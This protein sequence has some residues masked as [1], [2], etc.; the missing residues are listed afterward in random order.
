MNIRMLAAGAA[1]LLALP[2]AAQAD[3]D[4]THWGMSAN[5]VRRVVPAASETPI[6]GVFRVPGYG[7]D[8]TQ[9]ANVYLYTRIDRQDRTY[10]VRMG[11]V[12]DKLKSVEFA[13]INATEQL[14]TT[15]RTNLVQRFGTPLGG[16]AG[17]GGR[18]DTWNGD[19]DLVV[20]IYRTEPAPRC[21]ILYAPNK[22]P[23]TG[24]HPPPRPVTVA[25]R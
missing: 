8:K 21:I 1:A 22:Q 7:D 10:D 5:E 18:Y 2:A 20:F 15:A 24:Y 23:N 19:T 17:E 4:P 14:C 9:T 25:A 13:L 3:W 11:F 16:G 6:S 12:D